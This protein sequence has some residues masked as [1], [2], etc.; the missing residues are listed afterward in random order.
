MRVFGTVVLLML[1]VAGDQPPELFQTVDIVIR[2]GTIYDGSGSAPF[3]G[4]LAIQHDTIAVV[5][6]IGRIRA[7]TEID[8]TGLAVSPGFINM[9]SWADESLLVDGTSMSDI[10]QGITLEVMGEGWSPGPVKRKPGHEGDSLWTTLGGYFDWLMKKGVSPNVASFV[11]HTSVRTY[12]MG[13]ANRKSTPAELT[14]MKELVALAME[15]GALG[16]GTSLIYP[17]A[18][19][20]STMELIE[21][22][23]V[24]A[25]YDGIYTTHMRSEADF[26]LEALD[27]A[28]MIA[29]EAGIPVEIYHLK[30]S[31]PR[32]WNKL[33]AVLAKIDSAQKAGLKITANMYPYIASA[34]GLTSRIPNW[35]QEGGEGAMRR[36][37]KNPSVRRRVLAEMA[38]GRPYKNS[39]PK[40]V[41]LLA[42]KSDSLNRLYSGKRLDVVS[43]LHGKNADETVLDLVVEDKS[44]IEALYFLISEG[45]V[46]KI[47]QL[48]YVSFG[49]DAGSL[50]ISPKFSEWLVH[51]RA[52]GTFPRVLGKYVREEKLLS[53]EEAIRRMTSLPASN[54][55]LSRRGALKRGYYA[56]VVVFDATSIRDQATFENPARFATGMIH[57]LVN[58][59][60]VLLEGLHTGQMPGRII[61]R[62]D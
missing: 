61:R 26:I 57:V 11:G 16:L 12:V 7:H 21:L 47:I 5:G 1:F 14:A 20:S 54:L 30:V 50:D 19:Y 29:Q 55:G 15:E 60:P 59:T 3:V 48:P 27:E 38:S 17:P 34:T 23:R 37:L 36:S 4:D 33:E 24:A 45:N 31:L 10:T 13:Y 35:V 25:K 46:K 6:S 28:F 49:T 62:N 2:N 39:D 44:R 52:Y 58:G 32:N 43:S 56:D 22:A 8:A 51:P 40:D 9:L 53:L 41:L 42:F 18:S